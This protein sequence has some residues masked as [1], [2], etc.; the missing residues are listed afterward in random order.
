MGEWYYIVGVDNGI[1]TSIFLNGIEVDNITSIPIPNSTHDLSIGARNNDGLGWE[2]FFEGNI[3]EIAI[4]DYALTQQEIQENMYNELTGNE[5]GLVGYWNFNEGVGNTL[6]DQTS[7]GNDG[8]IYGATWSTD[9]PFISNELLSLPTDVTGAPSSD[10]SIPLTYTNPDSI[11]IEGIEVSIAFDA[12]VLNGTGATLTG[13]VLEN[14]DYGIQV[15]TVSDT[16]IDI[17][18]YA[19]NLLYTGSG[20][21]GFIEFVVDS[22][23]TN[24]QST[25]LIFVQAEV[26]EDSVSTSN[27]LFTV[28][29][30]FQLSLPID[31]TSSPG[32]EVYIPITL[33]NYNTIGIEGIET[34]IT[35]DG[36]ILDANGA[37]LTGSVLE[38]ENYGI[39]ANTSDSTITLWIYANGD[40]FTGSGD[41][42]FI[43]F[44]VDST[45]LY[46]QTTALIFTQA[47]VNEN[48]VSTENGLFTVVEA[49]SISGNIYY[50]HENEPIENTEVYLLD[51]NYSATTDSCGNYTLLN[52]LAGN[53]VSTASKEDELGGLSSMDASR[54][55]RYGVG[56]WDFNSYQIIAA[57]VTLNASVSPVDASRVARYGVGLID[58]L[59]DFGLNWTFV[60]DSVDSSNWPPIIYITEKEYFPLNSDFVDEDFIGI[61]LGDVTGN[62]TPSSR[63]IKTNKNRDIS[64]ILPDTT[65]SVGTSISL[66]LTVYD[67]VDLEGMD[68]AITFYENIIDATGVSLTGGILEN[69]NFGYQV[70]TNNDNEL[71]LWIYAMGDPFSGSGVV[72]FLN[73]DVV[74]NSGDSTPLSFTQFDVNEVSYLDNTTNGL[75]TISNL[76]IED[77]NIIPKVTKLGN[78]YPNPFNPETTISFME[79]KTKQHIFRYLM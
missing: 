35:F 22:S 4:W 18:I 1:T 54:I 37:T 79:K 52:I 76:G 15:N 9:V 28:V 26:N 24:Y 32:N 50:Y 7:N 60:A 34:V 31:A 2:D 12:A 61:R 42:A 48:P 13:G 20:D 6:F 58:S 47:E 29:V 72:A 10:V 74:G 14:E 66:P 39:Q 19:N 43:E 71:V 57:D 27:G 70:N 23:A 25:E 33:N 3:D 55:A 17:W 65:V 8:T 59:N 36:D 41:I 69:E 56:I 75:V 46:G 16:L 40:L 62:W 78:N 77:E 73:F 63:G 68:L 51:S 45:A 44:E 21:I 5:T 64:A 30:D 67:L 49:Y 11:G 53:Y 38:N